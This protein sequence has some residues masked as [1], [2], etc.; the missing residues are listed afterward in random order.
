MLRPGEAELLSRLLP[1]SVLPGTN[2]LAIKPWHTI[3]A[4]LAWHALRTSDSVRPFRQTEL[5]RSTEKPLPYVL[6]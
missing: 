5:P 2:L 4:I 6:S 1:E 3:L